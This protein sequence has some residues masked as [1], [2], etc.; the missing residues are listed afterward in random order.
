[1]ALSNTVEGVGRAAGASKRTLNDA[2]PAPESTTDPIGGSPPDSAAASTAGGPQ[3]GL[4]ATT[5]AD[6]KGRH[7]GENLT[8]T[9]RRSVGGVSSRVM[10]NAR[11]SYIASL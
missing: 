10:L 4:G 9:E 1:M 6:D 8:S 2:D 11:M 7:A 5:A 3:T